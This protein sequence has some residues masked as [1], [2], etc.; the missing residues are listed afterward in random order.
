MEFLWNGQ[1]LNQLN[2]TSLTLIPKIDTSMLARLFRPI[3]CCNVLYKCISKM[4]CKRLR[5]AI[6]V[7]V[8]SNQVVFIEERSLIHNVL[9]YHD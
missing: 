2:T 7:V 1:L 9:I 8:A 4:I 6:K 5:K 3:A